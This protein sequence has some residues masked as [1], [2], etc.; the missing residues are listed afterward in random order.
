M[1][2]LENYKNLSNL[3]D[4][5]NKAINNRSSQ[6]T[7]STI[8]LGLILQDITRLSVSVTLQNSTND[9]LV[10]SINMLTEIIKSLSEE[11]SGF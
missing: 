4:K 1:K 7:L 5:Y 10:N 8:E 2:E 9:Q 6:V 3:L 11:D